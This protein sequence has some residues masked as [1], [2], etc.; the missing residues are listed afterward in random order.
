MHNYIKIEWLKLKR[1]NVKK[2]AFITPCI[3]LFF[4]FFTLISSNNPGGLLDDVSIFQTLIFNLW[5][6]MV[7]PGL[8]VLCASANLKLE[9]KS[10]GK[11]LSCV[12]NWP[13]NQ[14]YLSK[15]FVLSVLMLCS[16]IIVAIIILIGNLLTTDSIGNVILIIETS[17]L[18]WLAYLPLIALNMLLLRY[19]N[20]I[21]VLFINIT[22]T[23]IGATFIAFS[24]NFL[25]FPWSYGLRI[26]SNTLRIHPNGTLLD[27]NSI[28][29]NDIH[30]VVAIL[31]VS[32]ILF[33]IEICIT[34]TLRWR[35]EI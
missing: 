32:L 16:S 11:K 18:I 9:D 7:F 25:F 8:I 31:V 6:I 30:T 17:V 12:N 29:F 27:K 34:K 5:T 14:W 33:I 19:I 13:L 22:L 24:P 21:L 28:Y 35:R 4:L 26:I 1:S 3:F 23:V 20:M 2:I 15:I 10:Y